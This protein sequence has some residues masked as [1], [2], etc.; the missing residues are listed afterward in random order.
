MNAALEDID[1]GSTGLEES[2]QPAW[3][4]P[5][6]ARLTTDYFSDPGWIFERKLDGQRCLVYKR[7]STVNLYSRN[8]LNITSTYPEIARA[9]ATQSEDFILDGEVVAFDGPLTSFS[10]LQKRMGVPDPTPA[11]RSSTKVYFYALDILFL[12]RYRL[13]GLPQVERKKILKKV[14]HYQDPVRYTAHRN[15]DGLTYYKEACEKG[16]E[17]LIAKRADA[18]YVS[19]RSGNWLKFKCSTRQEFVIG[20]YTEPGGSRLGFGALLVGYYKQGTLQYAGKVGTG[21]NH[22]LLRS[23]SAKLTE[24]QVPE[25]PF[26][27]NMVMNTKARWVKPEL[28]CEIG[29]TEWTN[30]GK[31]RH[32]RFLGMKNDKPANKVIR[33]D[34]NI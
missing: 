22:Q 6:R 19:S 7:G 31:L 34:E 26:A 1:A 29:F 9:F 13:T 20:G 21:F 8:R 2:P 11:L 12:D 27:H 24:M 30:D 3:I 33:E 25:P 18:A 28:V 4:A 16:W 5:M 32:P 17:G 14:L 15:R 10:Q 23:L